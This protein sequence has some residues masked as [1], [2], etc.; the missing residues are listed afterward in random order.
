[1]AFTL[2]PEIAAVFAAMAAQGFSMPSAPR[3][4]WKALRTA[5]T[6]MTTQLSAMLPAPDVRIES[7]P[8]TLR[9]G[10]TIELRWYQ[11][12]GVAKS[13][14]AVVYAH[15]GGMILGSAKLY[16]PVVAEYVTATGVPFL[17]VDYRLAPE[18]EG[19]TLVD[20]AF[21][22][23][24]WV[25]EKAGDLNV[26]PSRIALMGDSAGGGIAAGLAIMARDLG[27]PIARQILVYPMLDDRNTKP[28]PALVPYAT[29]S[30]DDNFTGWSAL[31]GN[32]LGSDAVSSIAAPARL[33]N[34]A[35][36]APAYI[37]VGEL[38]IFRDEDIAYARK[39][40][41]AGISVELHV[42]PGVP[43]GFD[44]VAPDSK[45][46]RRALM[47]RRRVIESL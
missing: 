20:D 16:D 22:G 44:R 15:G 14:A 26:D 19:T 43:H 41:A 27:I 47:D 32:A 4:D 6:A 12:D 36:L 39:L 21:A 33:Q 7:F 5:L 11:K 37:D 2:D 10:A 18:V 40:N 45:V 42:H 3:G 31:L 8:I 9:D 17:S 23:L 24:S 30:F 25:I 1:M 34:C 28:D 46:A 13:G 38:D 35:G 29:W